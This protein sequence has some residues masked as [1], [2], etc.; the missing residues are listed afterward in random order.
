MSSD[1]T[2]LPTEVSIVKRLVCVLRD[3]F[4]HI[5]CHHHVFQQRPH[6]IPSVFSIFTNYNIPKRSKHRKRLTSN[7]SSDALQDFALELSTILNFSFWNRT[8]WVE[9]KCNF[10]PS[11]SVLLVI[12]TIWLKTIRRP[13]LTIASGHLLVIFQSIS[14]WST[15]HNHL[16][17]CQ[18]A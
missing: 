3:I 2:V 17:N 13:R 18:P 9:L 15:Y 1:I 6:P 16:R 8:G 14:N 4:W 7:I 5:D 12:V 10:D 11:F